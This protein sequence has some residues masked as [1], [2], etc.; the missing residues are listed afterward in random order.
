MNIINKHHPETIEFSVVTTMYHSTAFVAEFHRRS[1]QL[2]TQL[3]VSYE[4]IFVNDGSPDDSLDQAN[5]L[6][7]KDAHVRVVDLSRNFGHHRA[8]MVGLEHSRGQKIF[9]R[10]SV[11]KPTLYTVFRM[12]AAVELLKT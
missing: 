12:Y 10:C 3:S 5:A 6:I 9:Q 1:T 8:L 11:P 4:I 2:L 7:E